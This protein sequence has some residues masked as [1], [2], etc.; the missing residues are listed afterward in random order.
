MMRHTDNIQLLSKAWAQ[1]IACMVLGSRSE[2]D[3]YTYK[4]GGVNVQGGICQPPERSPDRALNTQARATQ[5]TT[6]GMSPLMCQSTM[7]SWGCMTRG[8]QGVQKSRMQQMRCSWAG[9]YSPRPHIH[10]TELLEQKRFESK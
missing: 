7:L 6:Y 8:G 10:E 9:D 3:D 4:L 1:L 5:T 2:D